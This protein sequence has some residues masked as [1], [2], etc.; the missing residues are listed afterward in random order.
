MNFKIVS[1][2]RTTTGRWV[3]GS[4]VVKR[5]NGG[6]KRGSGAAEGGIHRGGARAQA[7]EVGSESPTTPRLRAVHQVVG[8]NRGMWMSFSTRRSQGN[9]QGRR[10]LSQMG[11]LGVRSLRAI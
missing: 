9:R 1:E 5:N 3:V 4:I 6:N 10:A 7:A 2:T 11:G 8:R